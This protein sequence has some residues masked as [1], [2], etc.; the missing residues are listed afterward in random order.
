MSV[1]HPRFGRNRRFILRQRDEN[2][3]RTLTY[4]DS[5]GESSPHDG[6]CGSSPYT[7]P[8]VSNSDRMEESSE[9]LELDISTPSIVSPKPIRRLPRTRKLS[10]I[11]FSF[12][13]GHEG[14][15]DEEE[16]RVPATGITVL[17]P[18]PGPVSP[19]HRKLRALRL[20]DTP[21]TPKSLLQKSRRRRLTD[22]RKR[23]EPKVEA[24]VNPFTPNNNRPVLSCGKRNRSQM[25]RSILDESIEDFIEIDMPSTK[26]IALHEINTSRYNEEFHEVC[27]L[28]DGEFGSV[29]KCLHRLD[30]CTYAIKKSKTP[31]AGSV[32]ERNA[33]NEVYAHA[34]LGKHQHVVRYYSAWAEDDHMY[35][36]NEYCNGGSLSDEIEEKQRTKKFMSEADV[37]QI[38]LQ[39]AQGLKYIHSQN[40]AHLDIKP[41][42][43]FIHRNP[44]VMLSPESGLESCEEDEELEEAVVY[45]IGDL[46][47][48]TSVTNPTVDEGDCRYLPNELLQENF[49]NLPKCDIF[50]LGLTIYEAA[51]GYDLPKN[52]Q[53]WHAIRRGE[54]PPLRHLSEEFNNLLKS[55]VD[56]DPSNRPSAVGLT[57]NP[58]LC[59]QAR[60]S[61]AQLRRELNAERFKN[62]LLSKKLIEAT[63]F[64][65][66]NTP[67]AF[68]S[69]SSRLIGSKMKRSMSLS[70]F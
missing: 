45:K 68:P 7:S 56:P 58:V 47:H 46:G 11:P 19:P 24:N 51:G 8:L 64:L 33:M 14:D 41:G 57:Q 49:D 44:K 9:F 39:I 29:H 18:S 42:N 55:M 27:K 21:H 10:S 17:P 48:V 22:E 36:Q 60:K 5:D 15:I 38:L 23:F 3:M 2:I 4:H 20:F 70:A 1:S 62:Q 43:I 32:Y 69:K 67:I 6:D 61:K 13:E 53:R 37:K 30:G 52:G 12:D 25:E 28:G 40:L 35:I 50:S 16:Q 59:P 31:V 26:K 63:Q 34:V 65:T 54:L 66:Q